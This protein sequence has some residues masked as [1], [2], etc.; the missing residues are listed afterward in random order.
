MREGIWPYWSPWDST[1]P[2]PWESWDE[3]TLFDVVEVMHDLVSKGLEGSHHGY[4]DCG[5]HY[6]T[7]DRTAGQAEY[8]DVMNQC[9]RFNDPPYEI[10]G[11]GQIIESAPEEFHQL[12]SAPVPD[13][14]E[15]DLITS[16]RATVKCCG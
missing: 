11:L 9:W 14:T 2:S 1:D 4:G 3:D 13:G 10:D 15:H 7:F 5:M 16:K 12:L 6:S 8:R